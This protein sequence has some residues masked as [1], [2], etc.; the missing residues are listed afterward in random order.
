MAFLCVFQQGE[1]KNTM[2][3]HFGKIPVKSSLQKSWGGGGFLSFSP[4]DFLI[5]FLAVSLHGE[6]KNTTQIFSKIRSKNL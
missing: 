4:F 3:K 6:L 2:E 5:A 1:F